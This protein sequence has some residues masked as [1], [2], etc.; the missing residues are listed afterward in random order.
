MGGA[1]TCS[2]CNMALDEQGMCSGCGKLP[3]DCTCGKKEEAAAM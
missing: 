1:G 3:A 2:T